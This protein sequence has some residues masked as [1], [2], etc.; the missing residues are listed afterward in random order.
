M[1]RDGAKFCMVTRK[2]THYLE[3]ARYDQSA[4]GSID[5][6]PK[7]KNKKQLSS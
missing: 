2:E 1:L 5:T 6:E 4:T 3:T 7:S